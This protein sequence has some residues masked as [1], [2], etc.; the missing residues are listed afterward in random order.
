MEIQEKEE[1]VHVPDP[2]GR[3]P[4]PGGGSEQGMGGGVEWMRLDQPRCL[5]QVSRKVKMR[6][7]TGRPG[8][9]STESAQ[10]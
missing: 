3:S 4:A 6:L 1:G 2:A 10:K 9:E 5:A 7:K 8:A